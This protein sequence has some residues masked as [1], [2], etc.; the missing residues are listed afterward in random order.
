MFCT[1]CEGTG[2]LNLFQI[3]ENDIDI[4]DIDEI[5]KW[6]KENNDHDVQICD[7]CGDG[8]CW[9]GIPGEHYNNEDKIGK[10]GPYEYNGGYC[11]C[12]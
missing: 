1:R 7:C 4:S 5:L 6:I 10:N 2:F 3:N 12:H 9:Y 8:Y 11:E